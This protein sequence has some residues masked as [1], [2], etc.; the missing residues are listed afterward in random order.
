MVSLFV[1]CERSDDKSQKGI[2]EFYIKENQIKTVTDI[3]GNIYKTFTIGTQTWMA[4]N[5]RV[6]RD[7]TGKTL[8]SYCYNDDT[9]FCRKYGRLYT[10]KTIMN[11]S[12]A[13]CEQGISPNGW[14]IPSNKDWQTLI[15]YLGGEKI[16]GRKL[17][18]KGSSGF[19]AQ[20]SGGADYRGSYVFFNSEGLFWSSTQ[21]NQQRAYYQS[22]S[23]IDKS[24]YHAAM[25][26][27]R[28]SIRCIK[29]N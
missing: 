11:G 16:A 12:E 10:W 25:K 29:D 4:E 6:T 14:H 23:K 17:K 22:I 20:F 9:S 15:N 19:E 18:I 26:N 3:D 28:I 1:S 2:D 5:F 27:A 7:P 21:I 24:T 8:E 13:E